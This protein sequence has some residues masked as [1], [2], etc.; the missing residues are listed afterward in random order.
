MYVLGP[1]IRRNRALS[2]VRRYIYWLKQGEARRAEVRR[3]RT[4][5]CC[6]DSLIGCWF[7]RTD[8]VLLQ[9]GNAPGEVLLLTRRA[10]MK[11]VE[12]NRNDAA[13]WLVDRVLDCWIAASHDVVCPDS[14]TEIGG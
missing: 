1:P 5:G 2:C 14:A 8:D 3:A 10:A 7:G 4:L 11:M 12:S 13:A 9:A 6:A